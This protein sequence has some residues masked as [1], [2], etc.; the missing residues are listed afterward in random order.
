MK[1]KL[2]G[3]P[4]LLSEKMDKVDFLKG[5]CVFPWYYVA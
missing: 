4:G 3:I 2:K 1:G 5:F